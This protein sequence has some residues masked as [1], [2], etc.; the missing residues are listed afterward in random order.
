MESGVKESYEKAF[1]ISQKAIEYAK[2]L[3]VEGANTFELA[4]KIEQKVIELGGKLAFPLN[5]C[6]NEVA[7]HYSPPL[8]DTLTLRLNDLVK[9]DLGVHFDGYICDRAFTVC[10]GQKNH[11][12]IEVAEDTLKKVL[13]LIKPGT[14]VFEISE[15]VEE[16]ITSKGFNPVRNLSG[17]GLD[18]FVVH[19]PPTIPNGKNNMQDEIKKD[20]VI[21]M[22]IFVT[23]GVGLVK[24]SGVTLIY[25][26]RQ[27]RPVRLPEARKILLLASEKFESLPFA[28][29]WIT[30]ISQVKVD[31]ALRQLVE[32]G[33]LIEHP[34]LK[35]VSNGLV[36]QAE[37]TI[38]VQ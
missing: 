36:A 30:G 21:A 17:H 23:D 31:L 33:A 27:N 16:L 11:P 20:Q 34:V 9:I 2:S 15:K 3:L 25:Q 32:V 38:I 1:S 7:A 13:Q 29:R 18:R 14:R 12:L 5:I 4:E 35:E 6:I 10:I 19:A 26:F 8:G 22:E 28:K 37:E 24:E